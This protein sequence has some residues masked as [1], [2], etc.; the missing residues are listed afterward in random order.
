M[1]EGT[2]KTVSKDSI[3]NEQLGLIYEVFIA[4][5]TTTLT[6]EGKPET[7]KPG[8][9]VTAEIKTK[10]RRIIEFFIYPL[11][12]HLKEGVSVR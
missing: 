12:K 1:L 4:P 9:S 6:V 5:K 11:V 8:M 3:E 7:L 10:K 2:V